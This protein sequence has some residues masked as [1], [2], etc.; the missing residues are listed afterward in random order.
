MLEKGY[1]NG[2]V[3]DIKSAIPPSAEVLTLGE[4][5]LVFYT[6]EQKQEVNDALFSIMMQ[7]PDLAFPIKTRHYTLDRLVDFLPKK[8]KK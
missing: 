6:P 8:K 1:L 7:A 5:I 3:T 4:E 2:I